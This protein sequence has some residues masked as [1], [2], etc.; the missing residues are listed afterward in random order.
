MEA[1][2]AAVVGDST[3][4]KPRDERSRPL[5]RR[6]VLLGASNVTR[7]ISTVVETA[8]RV[9]GRPLDL[10]AAIGHGRS[11]GMKSTVLMRS[12]PGINE[13]GLWDALAD[14]PPAATAALV[15]DI[16]N[17]LFYGATPEQIAGWVEQCLDRLAAFDATIVMTRMP[18]CNLDHVREWQFRLVR[19][20]MFPGCRLSL[21]ELAERALRLDARLTQLARERGCRLVEP[22]AGW[23]GFDP[24][25]IKWAH[26]GGAWSQILLPW[27]GELEAAAARASLPRWLRLARFA[28]HR[29]WI[30]G[31]EQLRPQPCGRLPDG[32]QISLY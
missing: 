10:L 15:T 16:G 19:G 32:T 30:L 7:G 3:Q 2:G 5:E 14:R 28:P 26:W 1:V 4:N 25:H 17:D 29:R 27:V 22:D 6:V 31:R 18:V 21:C 12:L 8:C 11:Y 9:W 24:I 23:Y 13:C 20:V